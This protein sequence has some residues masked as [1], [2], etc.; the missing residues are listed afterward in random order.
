MPLLEPSLV[1]C[2]SRAVVAGRYLRPAFQPHIVCTR[3]QRLVPGSLMTESQR[4]VRD[5]NIRYNP[6]C[7]YARRL[8]PSLDSGSPR[9]KLP[10][11]GFLVISRTTRSLQ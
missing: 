7:T 2:P 8:S 1:Q 6:D 11:P 9:C 3:D 10:S 5:I 4:N